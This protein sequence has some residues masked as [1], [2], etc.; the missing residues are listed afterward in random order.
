[1]PGR[2]GDDE[3]SP[4]GLVLHVH[5]PE[6][7][8]EGWQVSS[9]LLVPV[10]QPGGEVGVSSGHCPV[11]GQPPAL[12]SARH[13]VRLGLQQL[14]YGGLVAF[15]RHLVYRSLSVGRQH[16]PKTV[17]SS[18]NKMGLIVILHIF[19]SLLASNIK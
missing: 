12:V 19:N 15:Q 3:R 14:L 13:N 4:A 8:N 9:L 5:L 16:F 2:G 18:G 10:Q 7:D 1:M 6:E 11:Q 17:T